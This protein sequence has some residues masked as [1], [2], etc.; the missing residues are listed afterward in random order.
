MLIYHIFF[1]TCFLLIPG[2]G[3]IFLCSH[4]VTVMVGWVE[5]AKGGF[6]AFAIWWVMLEPHEG[7][8]SKTQH[9]DIGAQ[10]LEVD[11]ERSMFSSSR[12]KDNVV[13]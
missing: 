2:S 9:K 6:A 10:L 1:V 7:K 3:P 13:Y 4:D 8:C 11:V 12:E 5:K